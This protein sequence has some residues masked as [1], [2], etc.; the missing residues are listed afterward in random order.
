[1]A[2]MRGVALHLSAIDCQVTAPG[3]IGVRPDSPRWCG[4]NAGP[5]RVIAKGQTMKEFAAMLSN[6]SAIGRPVHDATGLSGRFDFQFEYT[7]RFVAG[8][9]PGTL[10]PNP[11]ADSG[12]TM[13]TAIQEQLGL[14]L[15]SDKAPIDVVVIDRAEIPTDN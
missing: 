10:V 9:E 2:S 3:T 7:P 1:M 11:D 6:L 4:F 15:Q 12:L 14:R 8:P 5:G 13:F